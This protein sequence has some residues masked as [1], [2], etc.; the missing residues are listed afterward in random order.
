MILEKIQSPADVKKLSKKECEVLCAELR[1]FL[2][3]SVS[4]TGGHL[5]SNLGVVEL[6]LAIHRVF[7]TEKDRLVFDVGHQCYVHKLLTGRREGFDHLRQYEGLSGFPKPHESVHDAFIAGHASNSVSV[8]LGMARS[9]T[10]QGKD[11][12]VLALIGDGALTGGLAYE[13]LNDA[14]QSGEP[15]IILLNDNGMSIS[16]NVGGISEHLKKLRTK[17]GY[18]TFKKWYRSL[19]GDDVEE[20]K[21]YQ[22]NH[23]VKTLIKQSIYPYSTLFEDMGFTYLGPVDGHDVEQITNTLQWAKEQS[24]PVVVHIKTE[25]GRG[26]APAEK[27]P[28]L[29]HGVGVFDPKTG[30]NTAGKRDFSAV[31]GE[32]LMQLAAEEEKVCAITAAMKEGTGLNGFAEQYPKRFFDV[33]IAEGHAV[34]LAAGLAMQGSI[35]VFAVYSTFLQ[36]AYDQLIHDISLCKLH[37]VFAVDRAGL[38]GAD[39]ETHHG[40][41]DVGYLSSVPGMKVFS[42]ANFAELHSMLRHAALKEAGSVTVRYPRGVEGAYRNDWDGSDFSCVREGSDCAIVTYGL[43]TNNALAAAE[44]LAQQGISAAVWKLHVVAPLN[45][46]ALAKALA[47]YGGVLIAEEAVRSGGVGEHLLAELAQRGDDKKYLLA[48]LGRDIPNQGTQNELLKAC[49]LDAEG[50]AAAVKTMI[51]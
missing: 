3:S 40:I 30:V 39:G 8:A 27:E 5:A 46:E 45:H 31:F 9:R 6:T 15:I 47:P 2:V 22:V 19:F 11:Y 44:L 23:C 42:P 35:P 4:K 20:N 34:S 33:G 32:T 17:R 7:D 1:E 38:V 49:G 43:L 24:G 13:G 36:R 37:A 12:S 29:Y 48:N 10:M 18:Y 51:R 28:N 26:Y 14:G 50:L 25:K 16:G 41:F 21:V